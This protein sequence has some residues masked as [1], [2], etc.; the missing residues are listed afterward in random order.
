M[1]STTTGRARN[2]L[3]QQ[4]SWRTSGWPRTCSEGP[5]SSPAESVFLHL[6][7]RSPMSRSPSR[8]P[9]SRRPLSLLAVAAGVLVAFAV[10]RHAWAQG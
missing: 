10:P 2:P 6:P 3:S 7:R 8:R 5:G 1:I 9:R 4:L